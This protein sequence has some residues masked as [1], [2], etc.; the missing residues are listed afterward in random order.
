[1]QFIAEF[2]DRVHTLLG[3][4][5]FDEQ[6]FGDQAAREVRQIQV[7][8][9]YSLTTA[10][11]YGNILFATLLTA[12]MIGY[13]FWQNV[14]AI[15]WCA[16]V[17]CL[18][19]FTLN[20]SKSRKKLKKKYSGSK[21]SIK[22]LIISSAVLSTIWCIPVVMFYS[23]TEGVER[24]V[25]TAIMAG[26]LSAG[27]ASLSR[28]PKAAYTWL[29]IAGI[30]HFAVA[31]YAVITKGQFADVTI[32]I[33]AILA[34]AGLSASVYERSASFFRAFENTQKIKEKSEVI[35]LLLKDYE[36]QAT[37]WLWETD[38][39]GF[40]T[41]AP[42]QVL[43]ML[44]LD[45]EAFKT[46]TTPQL[47]KMHIT[48]ECT[49]NFSRL[50][51]ALSRQEEFHDITLSIKDVRDGSTKWIMTRGKPQW[52][53]DKFLGYRGICADATA[54]MEAEKNI[55]YLARHDTLTGLSN[56]PTFNDQLNLWHN[57]NRS[58]GILLIDLDHFKAVNDTMG[59][60]AGDYVLKQV[61]KRLKVATGEVNLR[62]S[63]ECTIARLGGDEFAITFAE[64]RRNP[65]ANMNERSKILSERIVELMA[66]PFMFE[67]KE[68]RIGASVG[69]VI[70]PEDG[71]EVTRLINR[72]DMALYRAKANGKSTQHRFDY[73]MDEETRSAKML[74]LDVCNALQLGQLKIAYQPIVSVGFGQDDTKTLKPETAGM[75]ALL[76]WEHPTKGN[77]GP[78][79]FIPIAE[80]TGSIISIGE[81]VLKQACMEA[82]SWKEGHTIAVNVSVKQIIAPNFIHTVL[83][84]LASSGLPANR[85]EIEMTE[86]VLITD[87]ELTISTIKQLRSLGVR[88]SLDDFG[89]GYSSL[90]YIADFDVDRI[91]IDKSFVE[92]LGDKNANAAP[93]ISA[94]TNLAASLGLVTVGE[95]VETQEQ[96]DLLK[97]LGCDHL[98]GYFYGRPVIRD[99]HEC[100]MPDNLETIDNKKPEK[101]VKQDEDLAKSA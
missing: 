56:R 50:M 53:E 62:R 67:G 97:K 77:I 42:Q 91:K 34:T 36:S 28:V 39:Q 63:D 1:M 17:V 29:F 64:D 58:F 8:S 20:K 71:D 88:V 41:R 60:A 46:T 73:T 82:A 101:P 45:L 83:G 24:G 12:N 26:I 47:A 19:L 9:V 99:V 30:I 31:L 90:S 74:E 10:M 65:G 54:A 7:E 15:S 33:F 22:N 70:A 40:G 25:M 2:K 32:A 48:E 21:Q 5:R 14:I 13:G 86:S 3:L 78:D 81:W 16:I 92:K 35:D 4:K 98:Q 85:L 72:A 100:E 23:F 68:I 61:A 93:V 94:I 51:D 6:Q 84:A 66:E 96:A 18:S 44:G 87:P 76:R 75:E 79:V 11:M 49:D 57:A 43:D 37:E 55:K 52:Y 69:Y 59:H 38:E 27:A 80:A 89:T 95:G